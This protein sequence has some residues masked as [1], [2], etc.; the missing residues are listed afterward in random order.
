MREGLSSVS[1]LYP[2]FGKRPELGIRYFIHLWTIRP[3]MVILEEQQNLERNTSSEEL[4]LTEGQ[5]ENYSTVAL[6]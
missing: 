3:F 4:F 6:F 2:F 5:E 1:A